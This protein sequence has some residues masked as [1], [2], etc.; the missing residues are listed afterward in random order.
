MHG[1]YGKVSEGWQHLSISAL[2][3][4]YIILEW[5]YCVSAGLN[6]KATSN[7]QHYQ[8]NLTLQWRWALHFLLHFYVQ[9][10]VVLQV[11]AVSFGHGVQMRMLKRL[12]ACSLNMSK[13][14]KRYQYLYWANFHGCLLTESHNQQSDL[15]FPPWS[16]SFV[17]IFLLSAN[18]LNTYLLLSKTLSLEAKKEPKCHFMLQ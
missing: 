14:A 10:L 18:D 15:P 5:G 17:Q 1:I 3:L 13:P 4:F 8:V 11:R 9:M 12:P 16:P 6:I 7:L 2:C